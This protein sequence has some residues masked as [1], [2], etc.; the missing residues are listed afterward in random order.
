MLRYCQ[1]DSSVALKQTTCGY[2]QHEHNQPY[3]VMSV[4]I[5]DSNYCDLMCQQKTTSYYRCHFNTERSGNSPLIN[6]LLQ[7]ADP[8]HRM[9]FLGGGLCEISRLAV[10]EILNAILPATNQ[11]HRDNIFVCSDVKHKHLLKLS[12]CISIHNWLT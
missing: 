7:P 10:S 6:K 5:L 1:Q 2:H 8:P 3:T 11:S 12:C 4:L 9:D